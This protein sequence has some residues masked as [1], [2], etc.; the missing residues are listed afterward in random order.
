MKLAPTIS[1]GLILA[2][3]LVAGD[4]LAQPSP[5][6]INEVNAGEGGPAPRF[7]P[8]IELY[9]GSGS[10]I[11]LSL[12]ELDNADESVTI[13]LDAVSLAVGDYWVICGTSGVPVPDCDQMSA[14]L[15]TLAASSTIAVDPGGSVLFTNLGNPPDPTDRSAVTTGRFPDGFVNAEFPFRLMCPTPGTANV[16]G[17]GTCGVVINEVDYDQGD[18][19][20]AR[21]VEIAVYDDRDLDCAELVFSDPNAT[22]TAFIFPEDFATSTAGTYIVICDDKTVTPNCDYEFDEADLGCGTNDAAFSDSGR[23]GIGLFIVRRLDPFDSLSYND[24]VDGFTEGGVAAPSDLASPGPI[25]ISRVPNFGDTQVNGDDFVVACSTP[26]EQNATDLSSCDLC[27]TNVVEG[28]EE[29]DEGGENTETCDLD[30]TFPVCGDGVFNAAAGED[31]D[32]MDPD[33]DAPACTDE[34]TLDGAFARG[35]GG[36]SA[37]T[38]AGFGAF[39]LL[40][41]LIALAGRRRRRL[42]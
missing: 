20:D 39:A 5:P 24:L 31:C 9:N 10:S 2:L 27:G 36:C 23:H 37:S 3:S 13:A 15:P 19:D 1:V 29:C 26:G 12:F 21:F 32:P 16:N 38:S 4:A 14:D 8:Y 35:S 34:C 22:E 6:E 17:L 25:S 18:T 33:P 7:G 40:A 41:I 28:D 30:C 42:G 11:D